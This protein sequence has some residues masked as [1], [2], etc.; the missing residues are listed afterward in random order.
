MI[1]EH[2]LARQSAGGLP[3]LIL[4]SGSPR[5]RELFERFFGSRGF[6]VLVPA[7]DETLMS[8]LLP[9]EQA[10]QLPLGKLRALQQQYE[11]PD[12]YAALAADT[13]VILG[14]Q[15]FGKPKDP[16]D[17]A[18]MLRRLSGQVHEVKT[19]LCL[20][21]HWQ[22][23]ENMLQAV[24][25]TRVTFADL[26]EEMIQWYVATGEPLDKAGAYGIQG[27]GAALV[28]SI[29]GCYYNVMGLPVFR[30]MALLRQAAVQLNSPD[31]FVHLLPWC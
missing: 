17:A 23:T 26:T 3:Q 10:L 15:V 29:S 11:L 2:P 30:L 9:D 28:E 24:E 20:G 21:V 25:T 22:G 12:A 31:S 4:A 16:A 1:G 14:N 19:G 5:R 8:G 18:A 7:F 27:A 13:L 6:S